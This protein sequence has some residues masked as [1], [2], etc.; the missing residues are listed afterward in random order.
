MLGDAIA[1]APVL[2]AQCQEAATL[3]RQLMSLTNDKLGSEAPDL[4]PL[5]A[6]ANGIVSLL[7]AENA[8]V[9]ESTEA[10]AGNEAQGSR[11]AGARSNLS[12]AVSSRAEAIRAI[13]MICD[14][15]E[16]AEPTN[17]APLFLKRAR[18][19]IGQN[20]LQLLKTLAPQA[21]SEVAGMVGV[22]PEGVESPAPP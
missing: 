15:L 6:L 1:K 8:D 10:D 4:R 13:D 9:G 7:P 12:G 17:P 18:Q 20:F 5:Y 22:D 2:R 14:Y 11:A 16:R 21:L 3:T 19:L